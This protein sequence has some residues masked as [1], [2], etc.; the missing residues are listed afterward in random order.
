[1]AERTY[2]RCSECQEPYEE[3]FNLLGGNVLHF[4]TCKHAPEKAEV[5][6]NGE[7]VPRAQ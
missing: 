4:P 6:H 7:V 3:R 5:V 2:V 1:V